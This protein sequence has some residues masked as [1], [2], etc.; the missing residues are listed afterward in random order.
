MKDK[1]F[2]FF[3]AVVGGLVVILAIVHSRDKKPPC[4]MASV[5]PAYLE[6][7]EGYREHLIQEELDEVDQRYGGQFD[8]EAAIRQVKSRSDAELETE[9]QREL[10][11][12]PAFLWNEHFPKTACA[13]SVP[14]TEHRVAQT[15]TRNASQ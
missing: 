1:G 6:T 5:L 11:S 13:E 3:M 2:W 15:P 9:R 8:R 12:R 4:Q 14:Q 10:A 7:T